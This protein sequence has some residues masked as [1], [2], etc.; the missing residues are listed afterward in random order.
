MKEK[1]KLSKKNILIILLLIVI[2]LCSIRGIIAYI[3]R[4]TIAKN[5]I[6][7]GNL[8]MQLIETTIAENNKEIEVDLNDEINILENSKLSR[9]VKV[10]NLGKHDF[11]VRISMNM[12]G[13]EKNGEEFDA[14]KF[15][16]YN[17]NKTDW[18]YENGWYYYKKIVKPNEITS[19]LITEIDF[20]INNISEK[21]PSSVFKLDIKAEAVQAENNAENV[22]EVLGWPSE[23]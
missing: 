14:N 1:L 8:K 23:K 5:I 21:Y 7:F 9:L 4:T 15:V 17:L 16:L 2:A 11:F 13:K 12:I 18:I 6:T 3:T 10:K 22:L 20:D 19:N